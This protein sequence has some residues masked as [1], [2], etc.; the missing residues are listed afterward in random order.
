IGIAVSWLASDVPMRA[1]LAA[2]TLVLPWLLVW[3][4]LLGRPRPVVTGAAVTIAGVQ[5]VM[6]LSWAA[7]LAVTLSRA[8][9]GTPLRALFPTPEMPLLL[10]GV[11]LAVGGCAAV[12]AGDTVGR[13]LSSW[14]GSGRAIGVIASLA[15]VGALVLAMVAWKGEQPRIVPTV[16]AAESRR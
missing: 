6:S 8:E 1:L 4:A 2:A 11:L 15:Y 5:T 16:E 10:A 9:P 14:R 12:G 3:G 13:R 7:A